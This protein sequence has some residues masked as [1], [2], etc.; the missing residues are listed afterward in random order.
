MTYAD[1]VV[2]PLGP[3][4]TERDMLIG[5]L[6]SLGGGL[7]PQLL[8]RVRLGLGT[9]LA[10]R[11][12]EA[13][14]PDDRMRAVELLRAAR[15]MP[16]LD[17]GARREAARDLA[18]LLVAP[19]IDLPSAQS[20]AA[21]L[22]PGLARYLPFGLPAAA[23][24]MNALEVLTEVVE[25]GREV[26][27][28]D[29]RLPAH[30]EAIAT[31]V[32]LLRVA[33]DGSTGALADIMAA[34]PGLLPP[35]GQLGGLAQ[36]LPHMMKAFDALPS[37]EDTGAGPV[38]A[39]RPVPPTGPPEETD[40][41]EMARSLDAPTILTEIISPGFVTLED[42]RVLTERTVVEARC[43]GGRELA[44]AAMSLLVLGMRTGEQH[45]FAQALEL[46]ARL[47][48]AA[49][50]VDSDTAWLLRAIVPAVLVGSHMTGHSLQDGQTAEELV[51][52][53]LGPG[54]LLAAQTPERAGAPGLLLMN[55][56]LKAQFAIDRAQRERDTAALNEYRSEL[57]AL[58]EQA[59]EDGSEWSGLPRI[60]LCGLEIV[61]AYLTTDLSAL[62]S[63]VTQHTAAMACTGT[64]P[65]ARPLLTAMEAP[66][67]V[68]ATHLEPDLDRVRRALDSAR[69]ALDEPA[70]VS[71]QRPRIRLAIALALRTLHVAGDGDPAL[72]D[73]AIA[74]LE[75]AVADLE[76]E[77]HETQSHAADLVVPLHEQLATT[78]AQRAG[79]GDPGQDTAVR[80]RFTRALAHA[81]L[82]LRASVDDVLLQLGA[83][84]GLRAARAAG[85]LGV[86]AAGWAVRLGRPHE[87]VSCLEA[88]R[89]LVLH[90]AA[91]RTTMADQ[92]EALG[93]YETAAEWRRA[94][95][96]AGPAVFD[97]VLNP[98]ATG[99]PR[100]PSELRRK[101]LE[102][103]RTTPGAAKAASEPLS[104][105][106]LA[107]ALT[108]CRADALV[109]LVPGDEVGAA[110]LLR[111]GLGVHSVE[112]PGLSTAHRGP[113]TAF[114]Q[115]RIEM[116]RSQGS[117]TEDPDAIPAVRRP[118]KRLEQSLDRLCDWAGASVMGP[119]MDALDVWER[120]LAESGLGP[121]GTDESPEPVRLVIVP[122]GD[123]GV[124]PWQA[125]RLP[126]PRR[127]VD[128]EADP[129]GIP[130]VA[131]LCELAVV[132]FAAS[133]SELVHGIRRSRLPIAQGQAL[134]SVPLDDLYHADD[135]IRAL[136]KAYYS[137]ARILDDGTGHRTDLPTPAAVLE[138]LGAESSA[139]GTRA[140]VVH[141][142]CHGKA[143]TDPTR[144]A[145]YLWY[146]E[147]APPETGHLSVTTLLDT[148]SAG[149]RAGPLVV[150]SACETDL[151]DT[152]H[153]EALTLTTA[154]VHRLATDVIG[155]RWAVSDL[156]TPALMTV[157]HHHLN[158]GLA[159]PDALRATQRYAL[160][161]TGHRCPVPGL[162]DLDPFLAEQDFSGPLNWAAFI[163]QGNPAPGRPGGNPVHDA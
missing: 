40:L 133:G 73:E 146:D 23:E 106:V 143:G 72:L 13:G 25:L 92:L 160:T 148:P 154:L 151:S 70:S 114:V 3:D 112:L 45:H 134:V 39:A 80:D 84:H 59:A 123:L 155:S 29:G 50:P 7:E 21:V 144:S 6:E 107:D 57:L 102:L 138:V 115:A 157:L 74:E 12:A 61:R 88:G 87:A 104:V 147:G 83:E 37:S 90:A 48:D 149:D 111:P 86:L 119:V 67:L 5:E 113:L 132:T 32:P 128:A 137:K 68:L 63:A 52:E 20:G 131:H 77:S 16:E 136:A 116:R 97:E 159:P 161:P 82:A 141:M 78:L 65:F 11:W 75:A 93:A 95:A 142:V 163:H 26:A 158:A 126:L 56:C 33:E 66:L 35:D 54:G 30:I 22:P 153:D 79:P 99:V 108:R 124:V 42:L 18:V 120:A 36:A 43:G 127:S 121:S 31:M 118:E 162:T 91:V 100:L 150:L 71:G 81:R 15:R 47:R 135:E 38:D 109:Y 140:A 125:A 17:A 55:R 76:A 44:I 85:S 145:L 10:A 101:A 94:A 62:R 103:V 9:L 129:S 8:V 89:A 46:L 60:L 122:C 110:L 4:R 2:V 19:L 117:D 1:N 27:G 152:D 14:D 139:A 24:G 98:D 156:V 28:G 69:A 58:A 130:T 41:Q 64:L 49:H 96:S 53:A 105:P 34:L 51:E